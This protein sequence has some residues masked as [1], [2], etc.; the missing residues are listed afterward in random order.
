MLGARGNFSVQAFWKLIK[1]LKCMLWSSKDV[2]CENPLLL[3]MCV[4]QYKSDKCEQT[5]CKFY[6]GYSERKKS[7]VREITKSS[8]GLIYH[9]AGCPINMS[10]DKSK[11][12]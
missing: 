9:L 12:S 3:K 4:S 11:Y 5:R 6:S 1:L 10:E 8:Y 2:D 7:G